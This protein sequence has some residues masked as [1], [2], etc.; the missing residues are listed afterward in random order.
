[1]IFIRQ[2]PGTVPR[3]RGNLGPVPVP[4]AR[5]C[6]GPLQTQLIARFRALLDPDNEGHGV[7]RGGEGQGRR[8]ASEA[9]RKA[10]ASGTRM[11]MPTKLSVS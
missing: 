10:G 8:P 3:K 6:R 5:G 2:G 4:M 7:G 11:R 1:M 9:T